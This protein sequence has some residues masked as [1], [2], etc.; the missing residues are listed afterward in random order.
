M[1][2]K[3]NTKHICSIDPAP[4]SGDEHKLYDSTQGWTRVIIIPNSRG[5][6]IHLKKK[7]SPWLGRAS[8]WRFRIPRENLSMG[9]SGAAFFKYFGMDGDRLWHH[10]PCVR[11]DVFLGVLWGSF[12][13]GSLG[14]RRRLVPWRYHTVNLN[15]SQATFLAEKWWRQTCNIGL[16]TIYKNDC[17]WTDS[18]GYCG[19]ILSYYSTGLKAYIFSCL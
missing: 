11:G 14:L 12:S 16:K 17:S 2:K 4:Y 19:E 8:E 18:F 1:E 13:G 10:R 3:K 5:C 15:G 7:N 6:P 9:S